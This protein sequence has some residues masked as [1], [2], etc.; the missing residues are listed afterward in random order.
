MQLDTS[1]FFSDRL[2][3]DPSL[4]S[5]LQI[6]NSLLDFFKRVISWIFNRSFYSD[7]NIKSVQC[8][9][10]YLVDTLGEARLQRICTRYSI[11]FDEMERL[12]SPL[13]SRDVAKIVIGSKSVF[14]EDIEAFGALSSEEIAEKCE[15]L[16]HLLDENWEVAPIEGK[17]T[18]KPTEFF[19]G[20]FY[21]PFLADR[22]RLELIKEHSE[23]SFETF[24]HN[25]VARVIKRELD[26]GMLVLAP[27]SPDGVKQY[28]FVSAKLITANGM[29]SYILHPASDYSTLEPI[30]LFRGTSPRSS[31][32]DAISTLITDFEGD[33]GKSAYESGKPYER[34]LAEYLEIPQIEVGHSLGATLVQYRLANMD[35]IQ[36]AYLYSGPGIPESEVMKF[37]RKTAP[38][39]LTIRRT[40]K[41]YLHSLG[42]IHIGYRAPPNVDVD[43]FKYHSSKTQISPNRHV[44]VWAKEKYLYGIEGGLSLDEELCHKDEF[45]EVL[46]S[47]LGGVT[48]TFF[49]ALRYSSRALFGSR[50]EDERG[51][52]IGQMTPQGW[53]VDHFSP[54]AYTL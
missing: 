14:V 21:D 46:R 4:D 32:I 48:A 33:L 1:R 28:Y 2:I 35:H 45:R 6:Q 43:F 49:R 29:V 22:E 27:N 34:V 18:G 16:S 5:K 53:R 13:L 20:I 44:T 3:F 31:E 8:F 24:L 9:K 38:V 36:R 41:D 54:I 40:E 19:A 25:M 47:H 12:G 37:N 23:D 52:K 39:H 15:V 50:A 51:V 11:H 42:Q 7:E 10:K 26:V 17:I 30:R